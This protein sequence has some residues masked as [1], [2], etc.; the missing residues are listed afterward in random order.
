MSVQFQ[1]KQR[2]G[3]EQSGMCRARH[4]VGAARPVE[5]ELPSGS[6]FETR[7]ANS[8]HVPASRGFA[9][10]CGEVSQLVEPRCARTAGKPVARQTQVPRSNTSAKVPAGTATPSHSQGPKGAA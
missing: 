8:F 4:G 2:L 7:N 6:E 9:G 1:D 5:I 3:F 10:Q